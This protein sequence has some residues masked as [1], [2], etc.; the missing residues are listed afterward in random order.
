MYFAYLFMTL[1]II[2]YIFSTGFFPNFLIDFFNNYADKFEFTKASDIMLSLIVA[3][4][5]N[6]KLLKK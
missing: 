3:N 6:L 5:L 2:H 4:V 1:P